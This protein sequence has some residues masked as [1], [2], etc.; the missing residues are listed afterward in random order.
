MTLIPEG[1]CRA[2]VSFNAGTGTPSISYAFNATITD[3]GVGRFTINFAAPLAADY[4]FNGSARHSGTSSALGSMV[5]L[6][7]Q[8]T[9]AEAASSCRTCVIYE[10]SGAFEDSPEI[11][12][13][14]TGATA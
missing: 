2:A 7:R 11:C 4:A 12:L 3:T 14:F 8:S 10:S 13:W 6:T 9:D 5:S 1:A